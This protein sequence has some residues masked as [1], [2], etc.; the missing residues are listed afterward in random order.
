MTVLWL[1]WSDC[2]TGQMAHGFTFWCWSNLSSNSLQHIFCCG[3]H[4]FA[5]CKYHIK[6]FNQSFDQIHVGVTCT[7]N[8]RLYLSIILNCR[9]FSQKHST[10]NEFPQLIQIYQEKYSDHL[11]IKHFNLV[12]KKFHA[13]ENWM[14]F[15]KLKTFL[16]VL[17]DEYYHVLIHFNLKLP[18]K[19]NN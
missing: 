15:L 4:S 3:C 12:I 13:L 19:S 1:K 18:A 17:K 10:C 16:F 5:I 14:Y 9:I 8:V 7:V 6:F 11:I 2:W